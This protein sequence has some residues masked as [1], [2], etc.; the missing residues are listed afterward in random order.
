MALPLCCARRASRLDVFVVEFAHQLAD[1]LHLA[2]AAFKVGDALGLGHGV[3]QLVIQ[4][5]LVQ[6]ALAQIGAQRQQVFAKLLALVALAFQVGFAGRVCAFELA[7]VGQVELAAFGHEH[8][9]DK[10]AFFGFSR[11]LGVNLRAVKP[12]TGWQV[13]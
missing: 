9:T 13:S 11:H 6:Q 4:V 12:L 5:A 7:L 3:H 8:A 10:I 1:E 2:P